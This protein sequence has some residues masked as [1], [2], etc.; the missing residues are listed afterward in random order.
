[1]T[2]AACNARP[3]PK[4]R[5]SAPS[6]RTRIAIGMHRPGHMS[7]PT[8]RMSAIT[9]TYLGNRR[10]I[11]TTTKC[12]MAKIEMSLAVNLPH[13]CH[14]LCRSS[15]PWCRVD[16]ELRDQFS[17]FQVND[18]CQLPSKSYLPVRVVWYLPIVPSQFSP[19]RTAPSN[20]EATLAVTRHDVSNA[21]RSTLLSCFWG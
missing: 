9:S 13:I 7:G 10:Y 3:P 20:Q 4:L 16:A 11:P 6:T 19:S 8:S 12:S 18:G 2:S 14:S 1:M 17:K 5:V 15:S 21:P